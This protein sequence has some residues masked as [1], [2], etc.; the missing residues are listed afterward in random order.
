M[1]HKKNIIFVRY[2]EGVGVGGGGR[3]E[4]DL[5]SDSLYHI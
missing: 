4:G 5:E 3:K 1:V 2:L